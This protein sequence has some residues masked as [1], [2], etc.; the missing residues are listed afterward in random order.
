MVGLLGGATERQNYHV[1]APDQRHAW[2]I[3]VWRNGGTHRGDGKRLTDYWAFGRPIL[4]PAPARVIEAIN[5]CPTTSRATWTRYV[6]PVTTS[7]STW[8]TAST[9]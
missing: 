1:I 9:P 6:P 5:S 2:D 7:S 4:S 8:A 3:L